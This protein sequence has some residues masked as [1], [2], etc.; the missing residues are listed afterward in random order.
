MDGKSYICVQHGRPEGS[1]FIEH[2]ETEDAWRVLSL[3][4]V[5]ATDKKARELQLALAGNHHVPISARLRIID[6]LMGRA[7]SLDIN[8]LVESLLSEDD[9][10]LKQAGEQ[11]DKASKV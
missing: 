9:P 5:T 6:R 7:S 2:L 1:K 4:S 8:G 3:L 11:L 10:R